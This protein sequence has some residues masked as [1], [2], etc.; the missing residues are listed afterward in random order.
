MN[1]KSINFWYINNK[2]ALDYLFY[3]LIK[4]S[5]TYGI[6]IIDNNKSYDNFIEMMYNESN[7]NIIDK[8]LYPELYKKYSNDDTLDNYKIL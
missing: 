8:R 4:I 7:G 3:N 2:V 5:K 1:K 6:I